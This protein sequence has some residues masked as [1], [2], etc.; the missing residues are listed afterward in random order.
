MNKKLFS[1]A[2][3]AIVLVFGMA[4]IGCD[5]DPDNGG[6]NDDVDSV[7]IKT[8][9]PNASLIDGVDQQFIIT[10]DYK[11]L[12]LEQGRLDIGFNTDQLNS[13]RVFNK[14]IVSKGNGTRTFN[15]SV[16]LKNWFPDG[17]FQVRAYLAPPALTE[18]SRALAWDSKILSFK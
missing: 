15:L 14:E 1:P 17:E 5:N 9:T 4:V 18:G 16:R 11:L 7:I 8:V 2:I 6:G 12:T 10:V 3:L 13:Y